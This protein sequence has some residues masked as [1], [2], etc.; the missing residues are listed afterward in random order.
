MNNGFQRE[1]N[2]ARWHQNN[3]ATRVNRVSWDTRFLSH[4]R[5]SGSQG[6]NIPLCQMMVDLYQ[7]ENPAPKGMLRSI[8]QWMK[9]SMAPLW[10]MGNKPSFAFSGQYL[11]LLMM[12]K[13]IWL[14]AS[15][16]NCIAFIANESDDARLFLEGDVGKALRKLGYT[17][18]VTSTIAY[19]AF[20]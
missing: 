19:Q 20:T 12:F 10:M 8:Q 17:V 11:L 4:L 6:Y 13:L 2:A 15:Y 14:Q 1:D 7:A 9:N 3:G 16:F 18:K 5:I